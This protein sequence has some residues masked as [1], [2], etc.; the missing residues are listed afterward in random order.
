MAEM[1]SKNDIAPDFLFIDVIMLAYRLGQVQHEEQKVSLITAARTATDAFT[2]LAALESLGIKRQSQL[3]SFV[4]KVLAAPAYYRS[5]YALALGIRREG[6]ASESFLR[7]LRVLSLVEG[8]LTAKQQSL[9]YDTYWWFVHNHE[10]T[11]DLKHGNHIGV[12]ANEPRDN[13]STLMR[14]EDYLLRLVNHKTKAVR[15]RFEGFPVYI[16]LAILKRAFA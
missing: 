11:F 5:Q 1:Q 14:F 6:E 16:V 12:Y 15:E 2:F 7:N 13:A 4:G 9:F 8:V 10:Q 3:Y